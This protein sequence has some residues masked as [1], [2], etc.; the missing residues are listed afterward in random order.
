M[1][2]MICAEW[3]TINIPTVNTVNT[4]KGKVTQVETT[5]KVHVLLWTKVTSA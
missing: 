5:Q 3:C 4:H 1:T 2:M